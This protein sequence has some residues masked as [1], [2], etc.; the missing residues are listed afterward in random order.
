[1]A[2]FWQNLVKILQMFCQFLKE[3]L[4]DLLPL[5][6]F[7]WNFAGCCK[8]PRATTFCNFQIFCVLRIGTIDL[9]RTKKVKTLPYVRGFQPFSHPTRREIFFQLFSQSCGHE[10]LVLYRTV[11]FQSA[12]LSLHGYWIKNTEFLATRKNLKIRHSNV[13]NTGNMRQNMRCYFTFP[14]M[15]YMLT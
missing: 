7:D 2:I 12:W 8:T 11:F 14:A 6:I 13:S 15:P 5:K 3:K 9:S 10:W 4:H 1:V